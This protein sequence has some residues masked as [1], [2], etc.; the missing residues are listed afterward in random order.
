[1]VQQISITYGKPTLILPISIVITAQAVKD[2]MEDNKKWRADEEENNRKATVIKP[3]SNKSDTILWRDLRPGDVVKVSKG[4]ML[5]ADLLLLHS[6][7]HDRSCQ[8]ET[9]NLDGETNLKQKD[10]ALPEGEQWQ[11]L[12]SGHLIFEEPTSE[13]YEFKGAISKDK[14]TRGISINSLLLR[15]SLLKKTEHVIGVV[16][17]SGHETRVMKNS[18]EARFKRSRLDEDM[19]KFVVY[20]FIL[21]IVMCFTAGGLYTFWE[22]NLGATHWYLEIGQENYRSPFASFIIKAGTWLLQMS[23]MVPISMIVVMTSVKFAQGKYVEMDQ[24]MTHARPHPYP[25]QH[26]EVHCTQ[27]LESIGQVTHVFSDKTGTL[28]CNE[29]RYKANVVSA[30]PGLPTGSTAAD[31]KSYG[32]GPAKPDMKKAIYS[33]HVDFND[34]ENFLKDV[35]HEHSAFK[36]HYANFLLCHALCHTVSIENQDS[37]ERTGGDPEYV[38]S[39]P[40]ELA[41][42]S[43]AREVGLE[44]CSVRQDKLTL[45]LRE[46][47]ERLQLALEM[48]TGSDMLQKCEIKILDLCAFDNERKCMS[49]VAQYPNGRRVLLLKGADTT[50]LKKQTAEVNQIAH[51]KLS[52]FASCGLRTLCLGYRYLDDEPTYLTWHENYNKAK[53]LMTDDRA[54]K[55]AEFSQQIENEQ[56]LILLGATAI[57][58]K[59]QEDVAGTIERLRAASITV[60][61]LTGD[62]LETAVNIGLSC[63][64]L[65]REMQTIT[66]TS[67]QSLKENFERYCKDL[68]CSDLG[69]KAITITGEA[70]GTVLET[71]ENSRKFYSIAW[72][73][74]SVLC[75]RV[76]P[77]QKS[78][79]VDLAKHLHVEFAGREPVTLA[80]GD[81][82]NDVAMINTAHVGVGLSGKEGA[83]AARAGDFAFAE[84]RFLAPLLFK[85][86]YEDYRRN[87]VLVNYN[88]YKNALLCLPPFF[89]GVE[90]SFS[91]QPFYD[92][93]LYQ[94]YN[95]VFTCLPII[96]YALFDRRVPAQTQG[97]FTTREQLLAHATSY[98]WTGQH[99][100]HCNARVFL[101]W[102]SSAAIQAALV[103]I[104]C[105]FSLLGDGS[106][107]AGMASGDLWTIG[108]VIFFWV[109]MGSNLT[110][111]GR[112]SCVLPLGYVAIFGSVCMHPLA[113]WV[114]DTKV[115]NIFLRGDFNFMYGAGHWRFIVATVVSMSLHLFIG[116]FLLSFAMPDP[117]LEVKAR[118]PLMVKATATVA[119]TAQKDQYIRVSREDHQEPHVGS[120]RGACESNHDHKEHGRRDM[121]QKRNSL[122]FYH[123]VT[124]SAENLVT[125]S[126]ENLGAIPE[127][128]DGAA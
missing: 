91:G 113:L 119:D 71:E 79:V 101:I 74:K 24:D 4:E 117:G 52:E 20:I 96:V 17:Y 30:P 104:I 128:T 72:R 38:A 70:L 5:P 86:G 21:L 114:L 45:R 57:D 42:V 10:C 78:L 89:Y 112:M 88:F 84:F 97:G 41:L 98:Y 92:Q 40:D 105:F 49:V 80:I 59:L 110:M 116:E 123:S 14:Q 56:G 23:N 111:I 36:E 18:S 51:A 109:I 106:P 31:W 16:V 37:I 43:F 127:G 107:Y 82:A 58:D 108:T 66:I 100:E 115:G 121:F 69:N 93:I 87:S 64:L 65:V 103:S 120:L 34:V 28:T 9:M 3:P 85:H 35:A 33:E 12:K 8:I 67:A 122:T 62:K 77:K 125:G 11:D 75:C 47:S 19:N 39:S 22:V 53:A 73:C 48:A 7:D 29:M 68:A 124:G 26:A 6:S 13:L 94:L 83:Q 126:A 54:D 2:F 61:V 55:I 27:V 60:W 90:M 81:G 76:S 32:M 50:V 46:K 95:V 25:P 63:K 99:S 118:R 102:Y 15:G 44:L 1:M